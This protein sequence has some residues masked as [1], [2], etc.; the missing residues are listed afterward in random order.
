M[1]KNIYTTI[2]NSNYF[3]FIILGFIFYLSSCKK[4][5]NQ[6]VKTPAQEVSGLGLTQFQTVTQGN[7]TLYTYKNDTGALITGY[8]LIYIQLKDNQTGSYI[9]NGNLSWNP[10]MYMTGGIMNTP[11]SGIQKVANTNTLYQGYVIFTMPTA[12]FPPSMAGWWQL[13]YFYL[14]STNPTDTIVKIAKTVIVNSAPA[15]NTTWFQTFP[16]STWYLLALAN[17]VNP[18]VGNNVTSVVL[19]QSGMV[20]NKISNYTIQIYP[21]MPGMSMNTSTTTLTYSSSA[22]LYQGNINFSMTGVWRL[23]L[24]VT[25]AQ[26]QA[27][28]V[29]SVMAPSDSIYFQFNIK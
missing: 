26:N 19:Y 27:I 15:V 8:N 3:F 13:N 12:T 7:Y 29:G 16:D 1:I 6:T 17:P 22:G 2:K 21:W 18:A 11:F 23:N 25:N 14:N 9:E 24:A 4:D 28:T 10:I 20:F 5:N